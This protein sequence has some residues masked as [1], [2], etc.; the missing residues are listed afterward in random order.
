M[1]TGL[2]MAA[3]PWPGQSRQSKHCLQLL[4]CAN[5]SKLVSSLQSSLESP[6]NLD[7]CENWRRCSDWGSGHGRLW[8]A[9]VAKT[10]CPG[11]WAMRLTGRNIYRPASKNA[12]ELTKGIVSSM[13]FKCFLRY[14]SPGLVVI[15]SAR[16]FWYLQKIRQDSTRSHS[17]FNLA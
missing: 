16:F 14:T 9:L 15:S 3:F 13:Q 7:C 1:D 6:S 11:C 5:M 17:I 10:V 4:V 12:F 2:V 8:R